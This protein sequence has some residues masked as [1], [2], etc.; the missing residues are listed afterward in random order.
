MIYLPHRKLFLGLLIAAD[1]L[2][3]VLGCFIWLIFTLPQL[4]ENPDSLLSQSG[5]NIYAQSG[6]L[7]YTF[8]QS[9]EQVEIADVS[10]HFLQ[11][12]LATEDLSFY[13]HRGYS[14]KGIAGAI[15][16][17]LRSG[18]KTRGGS[19][20]TQ[21]I[22][23]N[24]FLTR[25]KDYIRKVREILLAIQLETAFEQRYGSR[26]KEKLLELYING[27]FYGTNAYGIADAAQ[28]YFGKSPSQLTL[29]ESALLAGL[30]NAPSALNPFR[31]DPEL[32]KSR[33]GHVLR[34]MET[35][36]FIS[37]QEREQALAEPFTLNPD[38]IPR[39]RTPYFV[40]TIKSEVVKLWGASALNFG[41]LNIYTTLDLTYQRAAEEAIAKGLANLD[42]RLGF[43]P[44]EA[45]LPKDRDTYV[46]G[47]LIC[48]EPRTGH[49][50]SMVGGRDIFVSYYNRATQ[51]KRQPGSG[52][53]P[54]VYLAA[55]ETGTVSAI[56]L[57]MDEP[58]TYIVNGRAWSPGNFKDSYLGM[59]TAGQAL[60][61]SAN[62][63]T[64]QIA[65][66]IGADKI[67]EMAS[68]LGVQS[69][70]LPY[71][72]L[73]LGAQEMTVLDMA[74]AYGTIAGYGFRTSP[75]FIQKI[76]DSENRTIYVH[77]SN[78]VA[79]VQADH[80]FS[81]IR[82][83]QH[84]IDYGSGLG[85]RALGFTAPAAGKTGTTN[86]NT[87]A[88]FTGFTLNLVASVWVG[89]DNRQG[90]RQLLDKHTGA[91]ITGGN[92]AAPI[93]TQFMKTVASDSIAFTVPDGMTEYMVNLRTG[94]ADT[95]D[96]AVSFALPGGILP[97]TAADT[98][99]SYPA[100]IDT[101]R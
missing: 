60:V 39:N 64:V 6:E 37:A 25:D 95:T 80:V 81:L 86:D 92:G 87:D 85:V 54:I 72:S 63:A 40:E 3:L 97:N 100:Q 93:W 14:L 2:L 99:A 66:Q 4:P 17:N 22:V 67:V 82:L 11:A 70:L 18:R 23:K 78:P 68:R 30:P 16:D 57:F 69:P 58:R 48:L 31:Q 42:K 8:N 5:I 96:S 79:V 32:I 91:Q 10:P 73:A 13:R 89:F 83:M 56:S 34:R 38:R 53:K 61:K 62:A 94:M 65:Q 51:S 75:S 47:A 21:Q 7:L 49:I 28:T 59:T 24:V 55:F 44:Y 15:L 41:G 36:G 77:Q 52:F 33:I 98:L 74:S 29:L 71:P 1:A 45:S 50:K 84:V 46:Q 35:A 76:T 19:T 27:S 88:W 9:V 101:A 12:V 43:R 26:Y 90:R 20:L